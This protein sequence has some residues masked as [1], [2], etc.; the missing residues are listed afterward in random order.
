MYV[1]PRSLKK[2]ELK[3]M[4][5]E[6][7]DKLFGMQSIA[8]ASQDTASKSSQQQYYLQEQDR[9]I[10]EEQLDVDTILTKI[11]RLLRQDQLQID[12]D[13][14]RVTWKK[15]DNQEQR[16][17][18]DKGVRKI[19]EVVNFYINKNNLLSNYTEDQINQIMLRFV[20]ELNDLILLQYEIIFRQATF[21]ECKQILLE[22]IENKTKQR[23]FALEILGKIPS[24]K[25]KDN[26]RNELLGEVE[27]KLEKEIKK[28]QEEQRKQKLREYGMIMAQLESMVLA[29]YNRALRGEER[30]SLR[31][32][33]QI[34]EILGKPSPPTKQSTFGGWFK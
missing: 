25:E 10:A 33:T 24:D 21:E 22:R 20:T 14:N 15:L 28:I 2:T 32:H 11:Y 4:E 7:Q 30:G 29:T 26:I 13:T 5:Q 23:V 17:L 9:G 3:E 12:E 8:N 18:S 1:V 6:E 31:R 27:V 19:M 34:S 16:T